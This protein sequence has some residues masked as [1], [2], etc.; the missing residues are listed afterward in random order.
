[1]PLNATYLVSAQKEGVEYQT[2]KFHLTDADV[3]AGVQLY[4]ASPPDSVEGDN[5]PGPGEN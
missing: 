4:I 3:E 1:M 2:V 5:D